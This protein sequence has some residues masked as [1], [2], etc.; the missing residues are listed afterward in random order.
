MKTNLSLFLILLLGAL[1]GC[2][3]PVSPLAQISGPCYAL[4]QGPP[5][6]WQAPPDL[7]CGQ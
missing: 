1:S 5:L 3:Q 7:G 2:Q 4:N 6:Q